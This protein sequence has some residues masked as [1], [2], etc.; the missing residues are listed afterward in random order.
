MIY[1]KGEFEIKLT[2][3]NSYQRD[4]HDNVISFDHHYTH[5]EEQPNVQIGIS[6]YRNGLRINGALVAGAQGT[7][8]IHEKSQI[9]HENAIA[10]CCSNL[11]FKLSLP[12]LQL[13]WV[14]EADYITCFEI[15][16]I[17]DDYVIHGEASISRLAGN[18]QLIWQRSGKDIFVTIDEVADD[19][20]VEN[21]CILAT[22][23][24]GNR[25][26]F[27]LDGEEISI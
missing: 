13:L 20:T 26:R 2:L 15:F 14:T 1:K 3:E 10:I 11:V 9:I 6:I 19:F 22:D 8:G 12:G 27:N 24:E 23:F 21:N 17:N 7:T 25:Y 4:S 5:G 18:G 16:E